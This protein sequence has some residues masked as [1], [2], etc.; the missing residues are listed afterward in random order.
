MG[1]TA[2]GI[3][4]TQSGM[5]RRSGGFV[6]EFV[7]FAALS[8]RRNILESFGI[9]DRAN[10]PG[11]PP[12]RHLTGRLTQSSAPLRRSAFAITETELRL[13]AAAA[14]IGDKSRCSHGYSTPA[15]MGTPT[16]L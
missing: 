16:A 4:K 9:Q 7:A 11:A 8:L 13:I 6:Q 14:S 12:L 5:R 3:S 15:A 10:S 2:L 1:L